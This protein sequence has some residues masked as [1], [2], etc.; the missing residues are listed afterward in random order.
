MD[1]FNLLGIMKDQPVKGQFLGYLFWNRLMS[2]S[3]ENISIQSAG[4]FWTFPAILWCLFGRGCGSRFDIIKGGVNPRWFEPEFPLILAGSRTYLANELFWYTDGLT[5][6]SGLLRHVVSKDKQ[7]PP[8]FEE[9]LRKIQ[10]PLWSKT[11]LAPQWNVP[12]SLF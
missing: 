10:Q 3:R 12:S 2:H 5:T 7:R 8:F 6:D 1:W 4:H 9:K 11:P